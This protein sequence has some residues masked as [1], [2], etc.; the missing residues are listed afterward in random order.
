MGQ[1]AGYRPDNAITK[2]R[3]KNEKDICCYAVCIAFALPQR[4]SNSRTAVLGII[5]CR[6]KYSY[7][8]RYYAIQTFVDQAMD[9]SVFETDTDKKIDSFSPARSSDFWGICW[10][11]DT[12]NIWTQSADIGTYCFEFKDGKW[13][14]N[15]SIK[16]PD[17]II[18]RYNEEYRN[19][20]EL[21]KSMYKS[22]TG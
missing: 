12:Y 14:R 5:Y 8:H 4:M 21:Q 9:V 2:C 15:E 6:K 3:N 17:Y 13:I 1:T 11:N 19:N 10:E 16:E 18:S 7:D 20:K 22:P